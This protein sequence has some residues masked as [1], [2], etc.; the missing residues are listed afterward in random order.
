M[1]F[2]F[3]IATK[4]VVPNHS[5]YHSPDNLMPGH[6]CM[7]VE[8]SAQTTTVRY[9]I[10]GYLQDAEAPNSSLRDETEDELQS[11]PLEEYRD[12]HGWIGGAPT[13]DKPE[14]GSHYKP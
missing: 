11:R 4:V 12:L 5:K 1:P 13:R 6:L 8:E 7:V 9:R 2:F 3:K 14:W 10:N